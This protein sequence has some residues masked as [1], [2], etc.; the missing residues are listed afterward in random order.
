MAASPVTIL[1]HAIHPT[2]RLLWR[3]CSPERIAPIPAVF[4]MGDRTAIPPY[5]YDAIARGSARHAADRA[6]IVVPRRLGVAEYLRP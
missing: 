4:E 2:A 1:R 3:C 6:R 5:D